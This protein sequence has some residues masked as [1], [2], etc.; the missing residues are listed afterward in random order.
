MSVHYKFKSAVEYDTLPV[1]GVS[2]SLEDLK[3][4]II[5]QKRLGRGQPYDLQIT[6]AETKEVYTNEK[7]LIPKNS[8]LIVARVPT[9]PMQMK[10]P[11][12]G[13]ES[14]ALLLSIPSNLMNTEDAAEAAKVD[15]KIQEL[16]DLTRMDGSE[17]DKINAMVAQSTMAYHPSKYAKIRVSKMMGSVPLDYKCY[18]CHQSGHWVNMCPLNHQ[19]LRKST[20]IPS[21]FLVEV[22]D[23]SIPGVMINSSGKFVRLV[24]MEEMS[25]EKQLPPPD[26]PPPPEDIVCLLCKELLR[27]AV[28]IPCCAA[29][30]CDDC[31]RNHLVESEETRCPICQEDGISPDTL[32]PNRYLRIKTKQYTSGWLGSEKNDKSASEPLSSIPP[33]MA[34]MNITTPPRS[35]LRCSSPATSIKPV[36]QQQQQQQQSQASSH[37]S[38]TPS[39]CPA[40]DLQENGDADSDKENA[41]VEISSGVELSETFPESEEVEEPSKEVLEPEPYPEDSHEV[42]EQDQEQQEQEQQQEQL[43]QPESILAEPSMEGEVKQRKSKKKKKRKASRHESEEEKEGKEGKK[44]KDRKHSHKSQE[45]KSNSAEKELLRDIH[46][47]VPEVKGGVAGEAED[48]WSGGKVQQEPLRSRS[49]SRSRSRGRSRSKR[50]SEVSSGRYDI[51]PFNPRVPPPTTTFMQS[52]PKDQFYQVP[53]FVSSVPPTHTVPVAQAASQYHLF[54]PGGSFSTASAHPSTS[55]ARV[56]EQPHPPSAS[57]LPTG[58]PDLSV[59]PPSYIKPPGMYQPPHVMPFE[60]IADPLTLFNKHLQE[61][62]EQRARRARK[63][64]SRSPRS[65]SPPHRYHS[66]GRSSRRSWTRSR[67]RSPSRSCSRSRLIGPGTR[68][69]HSPIRHRWSRSPPRGH[70]NYHSQRSPSFTRERSLSNHSLSLSRTPSPSQRIKS[71]P[72]QV[73]PLLPVQSRSPIRPH[74][75]FS[76]PREFERYPASSLPAE[77]YPSYPAPGASW[78]PHAWYNQ[79]SHDNFHGEFGDGRGKGGRNRRGRERGGMRQTDDFGYDQHSQEARYP[80]DRNQPPTE[81]PRRGLANPPAHW[82]R[83]IRYDYDKDSNPWMDRGARLPLEPERRFYGEMH[84]LPREYEDPRMRRDRPETLRRLG[85]AAGRKG[86]EDEWARYPDMERRNFE[87]EESRRRNFKLLGEF[88]EPH[89]SSDT[90]RFEDF[91]RF[92]PQRKDEGR[93]DEGPRKDSEPRRNL[94]PLRKD[95][96]DARLGR[97]E[98]KRQ[99]EHDSRYKAGSRHRELQDDPAPYSTKSHDSPGKTFRK[100]PVRD[101]RDRDLDRRDK[102]M[103]RRDKDM[104]KRDKDGDRK[105]DMEKRDKSG[106]R[107]EKDMD[108]RDKDSDRREKDL[109]RKD[110][111]ME[112]RD[113]EAERRDKETDKR[114][115]DGTDRRDRDIDRKDDHKRD[116]DSGE[117]SKKDSYRR[118]RDASDRRHKDSDKR[119]RDSDRRD[120]DGEKKDLDRRESQKRERDHDRRE[121]GDGDRY[122]KDDSKKERDRRDRDGERIHS[123]RWDRTDSKSEREK[124]D[125]G[126]SDRHKGNSQEKEERGR[127]NEKEEKRKDRQKEDKFESHGNKESGKDSKEEDGKLEKRKHDRKKKKKEKRRASQASTEPS[128]AE[129]SG[130]E[131][132]DKKKRKKRDKKKKVK[133]HYSD[134]KKDM[135]DTEE[136]PEETNKQTDTEPAD[137]QFTMESETT[138]TAPENPDLPPSESVPEMDAVS[139]KVSSPLPLPQLSKWERDE[140]ASHSPSVPAEKSEPEEERKVTVDILKRAENALFSSRGLACRKVFLEAQK[141]RDEERS[142]TPDWDR[143][144]L[145]EA[146]RR[147]PSIQITIS[148]KTESQIGRPRGGRADA[149]S[150]ERQEERKGSGKPK[151][152]LDSES[153]SD[154]HSARSDKGASSPYDLHDAGRS[155]R[156]SEKEDLPHTE[157]EKEKQNVQP[158]AAPQATEVDV[159]PVAEKQSETQE[160]VKE[161][162]KPPTT[163]EPVSDTKVEEEQRGLKRECSEDSTEC[164]RVKPD[165]VPPAT[166]GDESFTEPSPIETLPA[167]STVEASTTSHS[168]APEAAT[169]E[170]NVFTS[171]TSSASP[172]Q[173]PTDSTADPPPDVSP[174]EEKVE[175]RENAVVDLPPS[176]GEESHNMRERYSSHASHSSHTSHTSHSHAPHSFHASHTS[177]SSHVPHSSHAPFHAPNTSHAPDSSHAPQSSHGPNTS[178]TSQSSHTSHSSHTS[179]SSQHS[180][181]M[182]EREEEGIEPEERKRKYSPIR[183]PSPTPSKHHKEGRTKEKGKKRKKRKRSLSISSTNSSSSSSSSSSTSSSSSEDEE[184]VRKKRRK[185]KKKRAVNSDSSDGESKSKHKKRKK[186]KKKK[187]KKEKRKKSEKQK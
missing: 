59:P 160:E 120:R 64:R 77:E 80:Y 74:M 174:L 41:S 138:E 95:K 173:P 172:P 33:Y 23:P 186:E 148:S 129:L 46:S 94:D 8:S 12:D 92:N 4:A 98:G 57:R 45:G 150:P 13:K 127:S 131:G 2:I 24:D 139:E 84:D 146:K 111:D 6:N 76:G 152:H 126:K 85:E 65:R 184:V 101:R 22:S 91:K 86:V 178:H 115:K 149:S 20:G 162:L 109:E 144:E 53:P 117:G 50:E 37:P 161:E 1:D 135:E 147:G 38:G 180:K 112:R 27:D 123:S 47:L 69:P 56:S 88:D 97:H 70:N 10:K 143:A 140:E 25:Q 75:E 63:S 79:P 9:D 67:S 151:R 159:S 54:P 116:R 156:K 124:D 99:D 108:K 73:R 48:L 104:E 51:L 87:E 49:R 141:Q 155:R 90:D 31:I 43:Q 89:R 82:E 66:R 32:I 21:K 181:D 96:G 113:K 18:K 14:T 107:R 72:L 28:L 106:D 121:K 60:P 134:A 167:A 168:P 68:S 34:N 105:E 40:S 17:D 125:R 133:G 29:A 44:K 3:E 62:D 165:T 11:W 182:V 132:E 179:L 42:Q 61:K 71:S 122:G 39:S 145:R 110:K 169:T 130:D 78:D 176:I 153:K 30:F 164:K 142:P 5:Q 52:P 171:E 158:S 170:T 100:S 175:E 81:E 128:Q 136:H 166:D 16:T 118:D 7:T 137:A 154:K 35:P 55:L 183:V 163:A 93:R 102:E 187:K 58:S 26:R 103:D 157:P 177:H 19:D 114:E 185:K 36:D 119:S 83:N 15:R